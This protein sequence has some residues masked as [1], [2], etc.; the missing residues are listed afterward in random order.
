MTITRAEVFPPG[1]YVR[2]ELEAR[3]WTQEEF[4]EIIG[5]SFKQV[6][7]LMS[8]RAALTAPM[9]QV[10]AAALGTSAEVWLGLENAYR[11]S[12]AEPVPDAIARR[13]RLRGDF[14]VRD[15]Q[16]RGWLPKTNDIDELEKS[17]LAFYQID[18]LEERSPLL[19]AAKRSGYDIGLSR[20]QEAVLLRVTELARHVHAKKYSDEK[21]RACIHHFRALMH[22]PEKIRHVPKLLAEA[23]VR[24]V[25]CEP[26]AGSKLDGLCTWLDD[27]TPVIG[28]TLRLDRIDN[29]WFVLR[30][31]CEHVLR[32]DGAT[33]GYV[34]D[35]DVGAGD[36]AE[37]PEAER[38]ANAAAE[39]FAVPSTQ[40]QNFIDRVGPLF[41]RVRIIG[42]AETLGVHPGVVVGQLQRK[43][44]RWD[45]F[46][47]MLVKVRHLLTTEALTDGY[48][49]VMAKA[50][51]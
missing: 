7:E 45:L 39:E 27:Q 41:S 11:L 30:H 20:I 38:A 14:P 1:E 48:G 32:R 33:T 9:A 3:G 42:F 19:C 47:P 15:L 17:V 35:D 16:R 34:I 26:F 37:L 50:L 22:E 10:I 29:F 49:N 51:L 24:F 43:L 28:M 21:L 5:R 12:L 25:I 36:N 46:R 31:E 44:Q 23:G 6:N 4:A 8:G 2:D 18:S 40:L 13:S